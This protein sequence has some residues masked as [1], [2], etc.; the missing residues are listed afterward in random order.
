MQEKE[1]YICNQQHRDGNPNK[2]QWK[3]SECEERELFRVSYDSC[4]FNQHKT[5]CFGI[6]SKERKLKILGVSA[7]N[8]PPPTDL[9]FA[10]FVCDQS[11]WHGYPF[12][13]ASSDL[14]QIPR[15]V[16]ASWKKDNYISNAIR[17]KIHKGRYP[18]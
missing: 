11:L 17:N 12:G 7:K 8:N 14:G 18:L 4:W 5:W 1:Q 3:L 2:S 16:L 6:I 15:E 13:K 10:K 9:H